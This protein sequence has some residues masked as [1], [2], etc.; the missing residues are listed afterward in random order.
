MCTEKVFCLS[1]LHYA[2]SGVLCFP[3]KVCQEI[4]LKNYTLVNY[5]FKKWEFFYDYKPCGE[6]QCATVTFTTKDPTKVHLGWPNNMRLDNKIQEKVDRQG[7]THEIP[8]LFGFIGGGS[9]YK[10]KGRLRDLP[11][12]HYGKRMRMRA[13]VVSPAWRLHGTVFVDNHFSTF[14]G[15]CSLC[16]NR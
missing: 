1:T 15:C 5:C 11:K 12:P 16:Y 14:V 4:G 10:L 2:K 9:C 8:P 3:K 6:T 7:H 13:K